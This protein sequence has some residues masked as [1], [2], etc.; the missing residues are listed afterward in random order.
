MRACSAP[1]ELASVT[2]LGP[3]DGTDDERKFVAADG[4]ATGR[5]ACLAAEE[6]MLDFVDVDGR[7]FQLDAALRMAVRGRGT[8]PSTEA[9]TLSG[10]FE[11][12][13]PD[14]ADG[15]ATSGKEISRMADEARRWING[16]LFG[17]APLIEEH[18]VVRR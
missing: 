11:V 1:T 18:L 17:S 10:G 6:G 9:P 5:D 8:G 12:W 3:V 2:P 7:P 15:L 14:L 16:F 4:T 13:Y